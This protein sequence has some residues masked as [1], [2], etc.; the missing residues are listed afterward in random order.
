MSIYINNGCILVQ[1]T[2]QTNPSDPI[3]LLNT[4]L[5]LLSTFV[6]NVDS[7]CK[8]QD[9][10]RMPCEFH[11]CWMHHL[12]ANWV[13]LA[14]QRYSTVKSVYLQHC[15]VQLA[16]HFHIWLL[17]RFEYSKP[18]EDIPTVHLWLSNAWQ[19]YMVLVLGWVLVCIL[20]LSG[21]TT[22]LTF[23]ELNI[24]YQSEESHVIEWLY[25]LSQLCSL[26]SLVE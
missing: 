22:F 3:C 19:W 8:S 10:K 26:L 23:L 9:L 12:E 5:Q 24:P 14:L 1:L 13:E 4:G 2:H 6:S 16:L 11:Q 25:K 15:H 21:T 18:T 17:I 20:H 7:I